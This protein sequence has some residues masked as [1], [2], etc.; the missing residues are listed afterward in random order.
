MKE[1]PMRFVHRMVIG[2]P[3][4]A[5]LLV[6]VGCDPKVASTPPA[7]AEKDAP[8]VAKGEDDD[9]GWWCDE[10]GLPEEICDL[11]SKK[12]REAEKKKGNWCEHDRVKTSCFKCNPDL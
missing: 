6:A 11:C 3:V 8:K 7:K 1:G 2:L 4:L 12:Y 5:A 9:D 10:H